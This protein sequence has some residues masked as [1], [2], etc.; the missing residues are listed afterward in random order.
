M[1]NHHRYFDLLYYAAIEVSRNMHVCITKSFIKDPLALLKGLS[2]PHFKL[3]D[4]YIMGAADHFHQLL[5]MISI[6]EKQEIK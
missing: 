5:Y 4:S 2:M 1:T 3:N 6:R